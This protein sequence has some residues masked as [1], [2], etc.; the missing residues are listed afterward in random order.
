MDRFTFGDITKKKID[1][2]F[3][4]FVY[5]NL[6]LMSIN[7]NKSSLV[8]SYGFA[9]PQFPSDLDIREVVDD[10]YT[11]NGVVDFF[12]R[13]IKRKVLEIQAKPYH[14]VLEVKIGVDPITN[15]PM[16]WSVDDILRGTKDL[17]SGRT[18]NLQYAIVQKNVINMEVVGVSNNKFMDM[19]NFFALVY[20]DSDGSLRSVNLPDQSIG[21]FGEFYVSEIKNSIRELYYSEKPD[22]GKMTK[23]YF[24]LGRF[25]ADKQ[26][27]SK[28]SPFIN[29]IYALAGQKKSDAALLAKLVF[30]TG[31]V[32]VPI[33]IFNNQLENMKFSIASIITLSDSD[34][35]TINKHIDDIINKDLDLE[36]IISILLDIKDILFYFVNANALNFL[37]KVKLAPPPNKYIN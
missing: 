5:D 31:M 32:G 16:R 2:S 33:D 9:Y 37:R 11:F 28:V 29:S 1:S 25:T 6:A 24:S 17:D 7:K 4:K 35:N 10:G 19:S 3:P 14:W 21:N 13:A 36:N 26:L 27:I 34:L 22:F 20:H 18:V 30:H 8:G 23:R 15:E 12:I